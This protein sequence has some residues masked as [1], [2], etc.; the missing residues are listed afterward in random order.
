MTANEN[1]QNTQ[2]KSNKTKPFTYL[3]NHWLFRG[4]TGDTLE[5]QIYLSNCTRRTSKQPPIE[6]YVFTKAWRLN[7]CVNEFVK[8]VNVLKFQESTIYTC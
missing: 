5:A 2:P 4:C 8:L 7:G 3:E 6:N 1:L